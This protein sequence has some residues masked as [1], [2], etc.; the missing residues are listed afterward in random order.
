MVEK[1]WQDKVGPVDHEV[2]QEHPEGEEKVN[3]SKHIQDHVTEPLLDIGPDGPSHLRP[4][5][6]C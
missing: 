5:R 6:W 4:S 2:L 3:S 1:A